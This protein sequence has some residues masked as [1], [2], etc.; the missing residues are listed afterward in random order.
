MQAADDVHDTPKS[1]LWVAPGTLGA[2]LIF[3]ADPLHRST[4]DA[5]P[6]LPTAMQ[7]AEA[8]HDTADSVPPA[9]RLGVG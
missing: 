7:A 4:R 2:D 1:E 8:E 6:V 5:P 3:H 9:T